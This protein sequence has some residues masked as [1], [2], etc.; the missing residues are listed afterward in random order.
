VIVRGTV[1]IVEGLGSGDEHVLGLHGPGRFLGEISLL[2]GE[3]AFVS[4]VV[5]QPGEVLAVPLPELRRLVTRDT[6]LGDLVLRAFLIRRSLLLEIATGL[7]I[8]G[9]CFDPDTRRLRELGA[10]ASPRHH[11]DA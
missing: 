4:A 6:T 7:K 11:R 1:A 3:A 9:S 10:V 5:R 8:L 2:T